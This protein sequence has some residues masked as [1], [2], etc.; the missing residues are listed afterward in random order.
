MASAICDNAADCCAG[1]GHPHD[2]PSC[3]ANVEAAYSSIVEYYG[4]IAAGYDG[5]EA[6]ACAD[7]YAAWLRACDGTLDDSWREHCYLVFPGTIAAGEPCNLSIECEGEDLSRSTCGTDP[8]T[9]SGLDVCIALGPVPEQ[10]LHGSL[11]DG[12]TATCTVVLGTSRCRANRPAPPGSTACFTNEGLECSDETATCRALPTPGEPCFDICAEGAFCQ[13]GSTCMPE[14]PDGDPCFE[15]DRYCASGA[16]VDGTC[17]IAPVV[18]E[19]LCAGDL[20]Q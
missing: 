19:A 1:A 17:G 9:Q 20:A 10:L 15:Q 7:G 12:C 6:A 3:H 5:V 11:G 8:A 13:N 2:G 4:T 14:L 18:T 16:C